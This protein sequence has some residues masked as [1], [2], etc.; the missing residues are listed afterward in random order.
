MSRQDKLQLPD[1]D[2]ELSEWP[3]DEDRLQIDLRLGLD[4]MAAAEEEKL[5]QLPRRRPT[6]AQLTR[7]AAHLF[8]ARRD[9][10][11]LF[12]DHMFGEPAWDMLLALYFM[13]QRGEVITCSSLSS[14]AQV[15][16]TTGLRWQKRL[17]DEGLV[18]RG[19]HIL[20]GRQVLLALT[21]RG[22]LLMDEY[23]SKLFLCQGGLP[24][25]D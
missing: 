18:H 7:L 17:I 3:A 21:H 22:R 25:T 12:E 23:L 13:P 14:L 1:V 10:V 9:R 11:R 19:P 24:E 15:P 16:G 6:R 8:K 20:D 4:Q 2:H 5:R